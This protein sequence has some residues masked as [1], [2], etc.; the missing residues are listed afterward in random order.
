MALAGSHAR[1]A[2]RRP[3]RRLRARAPGPADAR[4]VR[5]ARVPLQFPGHLARAARGRGGSARR[6]PARRGWAE[7]ARGAARA[8]VGAARRRCSS[9]VPIPLVRLDY[10]A[11][12]ATDL[13]ASFA[14]TMALICVLV[15][16][17]VPV[18]GAIVALA[19]RGYARSIGRV[20]A[21]DLAGAAL[22]A[23]ACVPLLRVASGT[24]L[25]VGL[26]LLAAG[27]A[28]LFGGARAPARS[29]RR[30]LSVVARRARR[31]RTSLYELPPHTTAPGRRPDLGALDAA[32]PRARLRAAGR[33]EDRAGLL[34]PDLRAGP[35]APARR[36]RSRPGRSS[37]SARRASATRWPGPGR[38]LVI[39]GGGGRDIENALSSGQE[40]VDVIEL[41]GAIR[42][43]VDDDLARVVRAALLAAGRVTW[44]SATAARGSP[45]ATPATTSSTSASRTR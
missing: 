13:T 1:S 43:A 28:L 32:E 5:R 37:R 44:R 7:G 45:R 41:N 18:A 21:F 10:S 19:V 36:R 15:G 2:G 24:T 9:L 16:A 6:L 20:Y 39:G 22:G 29:A 35:R 30:P 14:L 33:R 27:A 38:T 42:D 40:R 31:R 17:P 3:R 12:I 34:R 11:G 26:A 25:L 23:L 8:L 4:A